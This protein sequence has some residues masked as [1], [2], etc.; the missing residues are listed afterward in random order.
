M[1]IK[2]HYLPLL[3]ALFLSACAPAGPTPSDQRKQADVHYKM[4]AAHMQANNPTMALKELLKAAQKDPKNSA[5]HVALAQVYQA[6]KAYSLAERHYLKA[7]D[8]SPGEP[9]YQNNLAALYLDMERW[10]EAI[11]LFDE[12]A[13]NLLFASSH[14]ALAGKAYAYYKKSDFEQSLVYYKE[15][16]AL[17][18]RYASAYFQISEVYRLLNKPADE[19]QALRRAVDVAP[20]FLQARYRLAVLYNEKGLSDEAKKQLKTLIEFSPDSEWGIKAAE[21]LRSMPAS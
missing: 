16:L 4:A 13:G 5:I 2:W 12:A 19:L 20:Q 10:D 17:A 18:P 7:L 9:R 11:A 3:F 1:L 6:K 21:L 8:L 14:V 15:S